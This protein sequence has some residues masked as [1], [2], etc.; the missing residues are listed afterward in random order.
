MVRYLTIRSHTCPEG[1]F[2][3][4]SLVF[5][6]FNGNLSRDMRDGI[7]HLW[8]VGHVYTLKLLDF[9]ALLLL[10]LLLLN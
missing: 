1:N 3:F 9:A 2:T 4:G 10:W 7:L 5:L 8:F 6:Q